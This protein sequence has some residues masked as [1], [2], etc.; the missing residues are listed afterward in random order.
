[1]V[2]F[3][4]FCWWTMRCI[5]NLKLFPHMVHLKGSSPVWL[6]WWHASSESKIKLFAHVL[7]LWGFSPLWM[8]WWEISSETRRKV[9]VHSGHFKGLNFENKSIFSPQ[10]LQC[11]ESSSCP[12]SG[13]IRSE[14]FPK[15]FIHW[16]QSYWVANVC[17]FSCRARF[18]FWPYLLQSVH[19]Q[20]FLVVW[21][22][23]CCD[24]PRSHKKPLPQMPHV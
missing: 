13:R 14:G 12:C 10:S 23:W 22:F 7:H 17:V 8:L 18:V 5:Y 20:A 24:N 6:F 2:V 4:C 11:S 15:H 3:L 21:I 16:V 9:I 19:S 1:M